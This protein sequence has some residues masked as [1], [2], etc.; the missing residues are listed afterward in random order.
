MVQ[1]MTKNNHQKSAACG[2]TREGL[3]SRGSENKVIVYDDFS[4]FPLQV[5][6]LG[7]QWWVTTPGEMLQPLNEYIGEGISYNYLC[8]AGGKVG[9]LAL[10]KMLGKTLEEPEI[11]VRRTMR[12]RVEDLKRLGVTI[13]VNDERLTLELRVFKHRKDSLRQGKYSVWCHA[14]E[15][16]YDM[17][18]DIDN[19]NSVSEAEE[20]ANY[21]FDFL[22][23]IGVNFTVTINNEV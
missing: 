20:W 16:F 17:L 22:R 4:G 9:A 7:N 15:C 23:E 19:F 10:A 21:Y 2:T 12:Q 8:E 11:D 1:D 14:T 13:D 3:V 6:F 18:F 5:S